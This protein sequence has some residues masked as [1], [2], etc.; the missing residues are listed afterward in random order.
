MIGLAKAARFYAPGRGRFATIAGLAIRQE[1]SRAVAL[2]IRRPPMT[3]LYDH[4]GEDRQLAV[5]R[6]DEDPVMLADRCDQAGRALEMLA[7]LPITHALVLRHRYLHGLTLRETG[8]KLGGL[9]K[10]RIR[11]IEQ[12]AL[13]TLR[14]LMGV[15]EM[16]RG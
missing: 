14:K 3:R 11:Q 10:E 16:N 4:E 2:E 15:Q 1:I 7:K 5:A 8:R 12:L 6:A 9:T 13:K